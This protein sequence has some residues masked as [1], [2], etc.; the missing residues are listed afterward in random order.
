MTIQIF[1]EIQLKYQNILDFLFFIKFTFYFFEVQLNLARSFCKLNFKMLV[2][3][4]ENVKPNNNH[5]F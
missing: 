2:E 5:E 4:S 1:G 3:I